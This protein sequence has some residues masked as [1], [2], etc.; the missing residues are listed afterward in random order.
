MKCL[1]TKKIILGFN[2]G[3]LVTIVFTPII[4]LNNYQNNHYQNFSQ[5]KIIKKMSY[6]TNL[7]NDYLQEFNK[8]KLYDK[9]TN[10]KSY[11][12]HNYDSNYS[13]YYRPITYRPI[14]YRPIT[15]RP[16]PI[17]ITTYSRSYY[18]GSYY[19]EPFPFWLQ[20]TTY[21]LSGFIILGCL[22]ELFKFIRY[23][24]LYKRK[25]KLQLLILLYTKN[26][27]ESL[28]SKEVE[29][30]I[31]SDNKTITHNKVIIKNAI[32]NLIDYDSM[33]NDIDELNLEI[34]DSNE[35]LP[36]NDQPAIDI[37]LIFSINDSFIEIEGFSAKQSKL[38][39]LKIK[40]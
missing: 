26:Y 14:T 23:E 8:D 13:R 33:K 10:L 35:I 31:P 38:K 22:W 39:Q 27:L 32:K 4:F 15:Y 37:T 30:Y 36:S 24:V 20:L 34:K 18:S 9:N 21:I 16:M 1:K 3:T 40:Q 17:P 29:V 12:D 25:T 6:Q 2:V 11:I 7:K 5:K 28:E 19:S